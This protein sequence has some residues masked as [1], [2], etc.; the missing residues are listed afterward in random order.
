MR[1]IIGIFIMALAL[2]GCSDFLEEYSQDLARVESYVDLDEVLM[3]DAYLPVGG[4][5][6]DEG[7]MV[8]E[9]DRFQVI[10]YMSDELSKYIP[11]N[12]FGLEDIQDQYYGWH[13]WQQD[14]G[15]T[16]DGSSRNAEDED[17]NQAYHSINICNMVLDAIDEQHAE[18]EEQEMEKSRIKG[19]A[20]FLRALYYF[21]LVNLYGKPYCSANLNSPGVPIKLSPVVEDK[22][23]TC[24]TVEEVYAQIVNDLNLADTCL[25]NAPVKNHPYRA[26]ITSVYLL[27]SRVYLYMQEWKQALEYAQKTLAKNGNLLDLNSWSAS[28]GEVLNISSPEIIFSMGGYFIANTIYFQR[29]FDY[30]EW[31]AIPVYTISDD[32]AAAY[33]EGDNDLR[34]QYY[35]RKD[36]LGYSYCDIPYSEGWVLNKVQGWNLDIRDVSDNFLFRTAEAY[37]NGAEAAAMLGDEGTAHS[38]LKTLRDNRLKNSGAITASGADLIAFIRD[39]RQRELCLEGHRWFDLR[40]YTV[41]EKY[42]YS[43]KIVHYYTS[44]NNDTF[45]DEHTWSYVLEE[46]DEAYTLALPYEVLKFQMTLGS[47]TRPPRTSTDY[48]PEPPTEITPP[49]EPK[50]PEYYEGYDTGYE[51]GYAAGLKDAEEDSMDAYWDDYNN[52]YDDDDHYEGYE[53][54]FEDGYDD[55]FDAYFEM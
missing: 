15:L 17:W 40:R 29:E 24:N 53:A 7:I 52:P 21:E 49:E 9:N 45:Q 1:K 22:D 34:T 54:G 38:L 47:N 25:A 8:T 51:D 55:G 14:V 6:R 5:F 37:L 31:L 10:H 44:Y 50:S 16:R 32:L 3:G 42:P 18:N 39:E 46:N 23:Y 19:E 41:N 43:K 28:K 2:G 11:S 12:Y 48:T 4:V 30:G 35:I 27:K 26:D 36:T 20:A 33:D 13:T